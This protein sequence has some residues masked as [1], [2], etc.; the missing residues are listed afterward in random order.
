MCSWGCGT[1]HVARHH[2]VS[3]GNQLE[4]QAVPEEGQ[5]GVWTLEGRWGL[6]ASTEAG[7]QQTWKD[8]ERTW[9]STRAAGRC[10][11]V[12]RE[13]AVPGKVCLH[14]R[15]WGKLGWGE[16]WVHRC[17]VAEAYGISEPASER[18]HSDAAGGAGP[19][20][21]QDS[22][23]CLHGTQEDQSI[24]NTGTRRML[25]GHRSLQSLSA[26][27]ELGRERH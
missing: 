4:G 22:A 5:A 21:L 27:P 10:Q 19:V 11:P 6:V 20:C 14:F 13:D 17:K 26:Y 16:S 24:L 1:D 18:K 12:P 15:V 7:G 25:T 2:E 9:K 3:T 23:V 8:M